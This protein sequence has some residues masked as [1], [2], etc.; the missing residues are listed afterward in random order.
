MSQ[1]RTGP[2]DTASGRPA[3][4]AYDA[5]PWIAGYDPGTPAD[6]DV[7]DMLLT[8]LLQDAAG[9]YPNRPAV[10]C[11]GRTLTYAQ[12]ARQ[13]AGLAGGL[14]RLD[15]APG[16]RVALILPNC[17]QHVVSFHAVL[18]LGAVVVEMNPLQTESELIAQLS[19]C[20]AEFVVCTD[21][22]Y[23]TI[24]A[25]RASGKTSIR[26]VVVTSLTDYLPAADRLLLRL[27]VRRARRLR[28]ELAA[29]LPPSA[30]V[31]RFTGVVGAGMLRPAAGQPDPAD[32][33]DPA[34]PAVLIYTTGT[35]GA[36]KA[37]MLTHRSLL[38]NATQCRAWLT[39]ARPGAE[40]VLCV[41][42]MFH[43]YGLT[44]GP[45]LGMLL[46][47]QLVLLPRFDPDLVFDSVGAYRPTL[48]P[49]VPP[50]F[51][52]LLGDPRAR[53][54]GL[55]GI[56]Y[57]VSGAMRMPVDVSRRWADV[58]GGRL[59]QGYGMTEAS[60]VTHCAPPRGEHRPGWIGLPLPSTGA[61]IVDVDDPTTAVPVGEP[62]E[63]AISG[64][65]VFAGYWHDETAT[66]G[67]LTPDGWLLTGDVARMDPDGWFEIVGR[68]KDI[69]VVGGFNVHP[70]EVEEVLSTMPEIAEVCVTGV[71]DPFRGETVR[72]VVVPVT[73]EEPT[74]ETVRAYAAEH[75]APYK[76]PR[77]VEFRAGPLPRR[78][79]GKVSRGRPAAADRAGREEGPAARGPG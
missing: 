20:G 46:G 41:L 53:T 77:V 38:A 29:G 61:R 58:T 67:A 10:T 68:K 6:V 56:R 62:G 36:A 28:S 13:V 69:I 18:R 57:C 16:G 7:P 27:P 8:G 39:G 2:S 19:D 59:L 66:A 71:P 50:F 75:L 32:P 73:G 4:A 74:V 78:G 9:R 76:V 48:F 40:T 21:R 52:A 35:T 33:A 49:G 5:R 65:Q 23:P 64:P 34:E 60:P 45:L 42:P 79:I 1:D 15:V 17:T 31:R 30:Q 25:A 24:D 37:A 55:G 22:A 51:Q 26:E 63:L 3:A 72:A 54:D 47:A 43:A 70:A 12:L 14:R 11:L 44:L